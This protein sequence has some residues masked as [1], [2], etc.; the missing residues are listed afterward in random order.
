MQL[1]FGNT[2]TFFVLLQK[3]SEKSK[4]DFLLIFGHLWPN[5]R[6]NGFVAL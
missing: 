2:S 1:L 3:Q 5:K 4:I 6:Y